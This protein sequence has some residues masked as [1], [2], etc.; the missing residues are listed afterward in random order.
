MDRAP[1]D[2]APKM[3][4]TSLVLREV[5]RGSAVDAFAEQVPRTHGNEPLLFTY[6]K[7][8]RV[9]PTMHWAPRAAVHGYSDSTFSL[10][11]STSA[12]LF[13][14][15]NGAISWG[16]KKQDSIALSPAESEI[17]AG[18][19]AA[20][21]SVGLNGVMADIGFPITE[22]TPLFMDSS[23]AIDLAHDPV[24]HAKSKHIARRDLFIRELVDRKVIKPVFVASL[25]YA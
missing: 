19:L 5:R 4:R 3:P 21:E 10:A 17:N 20:C 18:S 8:D 22:P 16:V 14:L 12:S 24:L 6:V 13:M 9:A 23:T 25:Q 15:G 7:T 2:I 1:V 11:H